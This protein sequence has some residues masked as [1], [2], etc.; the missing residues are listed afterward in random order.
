[1]VSAQC[2]NATIMIGFERPDGS[3][4]PCF[5]G[6]VSQTSIA[7]S[8]DG[9]MPALAANTCWKLALIKKI[10]TAGCKINVWFELTTPDGVDKSDSAMLIPV[11]IK[12]LRTG[13]FR[14]KMLTQNDFG[15]ITNLPAASIAG[16]QYKFGT[17]YVVNAGEEICIGSQTPVNSYLSIEDDS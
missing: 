3:I 2:P 9:V 15:T 6:N 7:N 4:V 1:M 5:N 8:P 17:G 16:T 14:V 10:A 13:E 12:D 11:T